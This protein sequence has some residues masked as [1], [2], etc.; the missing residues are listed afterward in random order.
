MWFVAGKTEAAEVRW[1]NI[2]QGEKELRCP[3]QLKADNFG[4]FVAMAAWQNIDYNPIFF[5]RERLLA[6]SII[7]HYHK[8]TLHGRVQAMMS[9]V[10]KRFCIP[11]LHRIAKFVRASKC[12]QC[13]KAMAKSI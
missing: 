9:K 1:L 10:R 2:A 13:K 8:E 12:N 6:K 11:K 4:L 5:A 3:F 7:E